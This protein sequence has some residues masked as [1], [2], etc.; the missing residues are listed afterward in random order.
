VEL[1]IVEISLYGNRIVLQIIIFKLTILGIPKNNFIKL[2]RFY[3]IFWPV[4]RPLIF[5]GNRYFYRATFES[6]GL[7]IGCL[8]A[9]IGTEVR[10]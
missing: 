8:A 1:I 5:L 10:V 2:G 9:V 6:Y 7:E 3:K 4:S